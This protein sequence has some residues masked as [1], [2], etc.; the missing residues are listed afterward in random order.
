MVEQQVSHY[1]EQL[2]FPRKDP[3]FSGTIFTEMDLSK[4]YLYMEL[5]Q[6]FMAL[7]GVKGSFS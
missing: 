7:N 1:W 3:L 4:C 5:V 2:C 6:Q